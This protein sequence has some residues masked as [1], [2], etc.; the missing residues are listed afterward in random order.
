MGGK[1]HLKLNTGRP[2]GTSTMTEMK[3]TLKVTVPEIVKRNG[4]LLAGEYELGGK[5]HCTGVIANVI[6]PV[7]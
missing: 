7:K 3:S 5:D 1:F 2:I 6:M 4:M